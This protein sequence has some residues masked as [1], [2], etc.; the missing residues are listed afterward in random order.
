LGALVVYRLHRGFIIPFGGIELRFRIV[1]RRL[2][3]L[4]LLGF[5]RRFFVA[6]PLLP[7]MFLLISQRCFSGCFVVRRR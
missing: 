7:L 1:N 5:S 3:P 4:T 6:L 2:P